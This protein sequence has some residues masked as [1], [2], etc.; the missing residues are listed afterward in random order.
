MYDLEVKVKQ[1]STEGLL[2]SY[3]TPDPEGEG[4]KGCPHYGNVWSCPPKMPMTDTYLA[5]YGGCFLIGVKVIYSPE[6]R[7]QA[8]SAEEADELR[9][10]GYEK[11]ARELL[12]TLLEAEKLFPDSV[13]MGA[14]RCILCRRCARIDGKPCRHPD[15][16]RYSIT[17]FGFDFARMMQD[18]FGWKLLWQPDGLPEYDLAVAALFFRETEEQER[19]GR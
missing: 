18:S 12:L 11:V 15:L 16:C 1:I 6:T 10:E 3:W 14:G 13:C 8:H 7:A 17:G 4:C 2:A 5:P 9:E 19:L